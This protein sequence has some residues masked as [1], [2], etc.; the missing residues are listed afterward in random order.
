MGSKIMKNQG[1]VAEAFGIIKQAMIE[2]SPGEQ[3]S[4]AHV[5]HCNIAM[6]VYDECTTD[7]NVE[8]ALRIGNDAASRFMKNCFGVVTKR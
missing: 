4:Y 8:D 3:G 2:D 7:I 5:W 1:K 6:A